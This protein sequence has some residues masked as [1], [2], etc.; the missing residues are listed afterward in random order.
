MES[1]TGNVDILP[2]RSN[3][4]ELLSPESYV[5][6]CPT[7]HN[8]RKSL[9]EMVGATG[10]EPATSSS[11]S[12]RSSQAELRSD[13]R[14]A[15]IRS[16]KRTKAKFFFQIVRGSGAFGKQGLGVAP[17]WVRMASNDDA[18]VFHLGR[19][20]TAGFGGGDLGTLAR[21]HDRYAALR[22]LV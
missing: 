14:Q 15:L 18:F 13:P 8:L 21:A 20:F 2:L 3:L 17:Y 4:N 10:F 12:W 7:T 16:Q 22:Q 6:L 9:I 1:L 5:F 11:Q 19:A